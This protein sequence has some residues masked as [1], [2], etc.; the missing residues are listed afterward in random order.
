MNFQKYIGFIYQWTNISNNKKYIGSHNGSIDDGY[1][2]SGK[3][4]QSAYKKSPEL[5]KRE[6]LEYYYD[7]KD[8]FILEQ[9]YLDI[10][11]DLNQKNIIIYLE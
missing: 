2:G 5:F 4:F 1:V 3:Y 11:N 8:Q 10:I 9:K 6:I 7:K